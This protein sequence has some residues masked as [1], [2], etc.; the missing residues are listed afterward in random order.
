MARIC[1]EMRLANKFPITVI[2]AGT[3]RPSVYVTASH[4][5]RALPGRRC[6]ISLGALGAQLASLPKA[7]ALIP[8]NDD[9]DEQ[10]LAKAKAGRAER[11]QAEKALE[12]KYVSK[13]DLKQDL[14]TS[15]I[16][17]AVFKLSKAG[18]LI[19]SG[20]L[21]LAT[22]ELGSG[23]WVEELQT[24][25]SK[26]GKQPENFIEKVS[27]LRSACRDG[28]VEDRKSVV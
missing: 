2:R 23:N 14:E 28:D 5:E 12:K 25:G 10:L 17:V 13:N 9:E 20:Y 6:A 22:E 24:A 4:A 16:Q 19:E 27:I 3:R 8:A 26:L 11:I 21:A 1:V 18:G 7:S 15:K